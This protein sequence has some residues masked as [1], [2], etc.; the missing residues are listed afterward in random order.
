[1]WRKSHKFCSCF[2]L[3]FSWCERRGTRLKYE[4]KLGYRI[5]LILNFIQRCTITTP[6]IQYTDKS[7]WLLSVTGNRELTVT[8]VFKT[9]HPLENQQVLAVKLFFK[10]KN[11][12]ARAPPFS[13]M[14]GGKAVA[15]PP[16]QTASALVG[17]MRARGLFITRK[18][19]YSREK[20]RPTFF[21]GCVFKYFDVDITL[22]EGGRVIWGS[23]DFF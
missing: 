13:L 20:S 11:E 15:F 23:N 1:M 6:C 14:F 7:G 19:P 22:I 16:N 5:G 17:T 8:R 21:C 4:S 18:Y 2:V 3:L 12:M 9:T 10:K